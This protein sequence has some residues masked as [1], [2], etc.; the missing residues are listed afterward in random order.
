MCRIQEQD[1]S[2]KEFPP[3]SC[4]NT[5]SML[6]QLFSPINHHTWNSR[7]LRLAEENSLEMEFIRLGEK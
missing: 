2:K 7:V 1:P 4:D 6:G 5:T 3:N